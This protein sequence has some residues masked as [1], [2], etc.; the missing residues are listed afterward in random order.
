MPY[1]YKARSNERSNHT[2][3][4]YIR[5]ASKE[6]TEQ[7]NIDKKNYFGFFKK[8]TFSAETWTKQFN[9]VAWE[10]CEFGNRQINEN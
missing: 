7:K 5:G 4:F 1:K 10:K 9:P 6:F 2:A 8:K 3:I